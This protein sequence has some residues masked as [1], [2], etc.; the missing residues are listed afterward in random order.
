[1]HAGLAAAAWVVVALAALSAGMAEAVPV[2][3]A[4]AARAAIAFMTKVDRMFAWRVGI[5]GN[6]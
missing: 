2:L 6:L 3:A 5:V 1:M 4:R